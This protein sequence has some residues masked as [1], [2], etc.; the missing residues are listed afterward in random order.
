M[1]GFAEGTKVMPRL[2][3]LLALGGL[4]A[5]ARARAKRS[6]RESDLWTEA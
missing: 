6:R 2:R 1:P 5:L 3:G 4:V